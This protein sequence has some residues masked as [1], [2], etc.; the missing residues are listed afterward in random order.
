MKPT[1]YLETSVISYL[2][3][4]PSR[5]LIIAARQRLTH[6]WWQRRR[7][8]FDVYISA[9]V[10][11]EAKAGDPEAIQRR[12]SLLEDMSLLDI[13]HVAIDLSKKLAE[14][15]NLPRESQADALH[16]AIAA[17]HGIEYLLTWNSKH[18]ANA[19][20]R[21]LAEHACRVAG[22]APPVLCTPDELMG[23]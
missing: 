20:L 8:L 11:E 14:A 23:G 12:V 6:E 7:S 13:T 21:P 10:I 15:I 3:A 1:V 5:D 17:S 9:L 18:I 2:A 4:R 16:I 19:E 22:Y